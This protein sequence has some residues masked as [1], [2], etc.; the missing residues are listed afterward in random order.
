MRYRLQWRLRALEARIPPPTGPP[1]ALLPE[2][3]MEDLRQQGIRFDA[4]GLPEKSSIEERAPERIAPATPEPSPAHRAAFM[5]R[6]VMSAPTLIVQS[7]LYHESL[8]VKIAASRSD[9]LAARSTESE[10]ELEES[11]ELRETPRGHWLTA[12]AL[13]LW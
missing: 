1:K 13:T 2:W 11:T 3:L 8:D 9:G 5:A 6:G 12:Y 7:D 10:R 4:T